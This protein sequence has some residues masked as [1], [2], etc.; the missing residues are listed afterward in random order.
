MDAHH[1][2]GHYSCDMADK[3]GI[4]VMRLATMEPDLPTLG[5]TSL[6]S[7]QAGPC[8]QQNGVHDEGGDGSG[9]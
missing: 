6:M 8:G 4:D 1:R 9:A 7:V 5:V 3:E 2:M